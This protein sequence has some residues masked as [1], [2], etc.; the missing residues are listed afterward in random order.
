MSPRRQIGRDTIGIFNRDSPDTGSTA[1]I[2]LSMSPRDKRRGPEEVIR[3]APRCFSARQYPRTEASS[4]QR[5]ISVDRTVNWG[6]LRA[7]RSGGRHLS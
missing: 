5:A 2:M 3:G 6:G 1:A 4:S 7:R